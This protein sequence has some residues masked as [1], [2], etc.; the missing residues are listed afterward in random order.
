MT[1][2]LHLTRDQIIAVMG[3]H[4]PMLLLDG[5]TARGDGWIRGFAHPE[6]Q[7]LFRRIGA[8]PF[9][10]GIEMI[11]Q[12]AAT[13]VR[14]DHPDKAGF[15]VQLTDTH[16]A[17]GELPDGRLETHARLVDRNERDFWVFAG[18]LIHRGEVLIHAEFCGMLADRETLIQRSL[19]NP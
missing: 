7:A 11:G 12:T 15:F 6:N 14:E 4:P 16:W 3:M 8:R 5:I 1:A 13:Y 17:T 9:V 18:D 19:A 2:A 10:F